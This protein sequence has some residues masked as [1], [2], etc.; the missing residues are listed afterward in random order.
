MDRPDDG[1]DR[2]QH[3]VPAAEEA[4]VKGVAFFLFVLTAVLGN[5]ALAV[6]DPHEMLPA[7][8]LERR[9]EAIGA[10]LRCLVCQNESIEASD[11]DLAR[12][13]RHVIRERVVAGATDRQILQ[14][15]VARYG[16]FVRLRPRFDSV[17]ALLWSAPA[18]ALAAGFTIV[19]L[20]RRRATP[21][22]ATLTGEERLR[23]RTFLE[24]T[25]E[26]DHLV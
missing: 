8:A 6:S 19:A 20:S 1:G 13:L 12:D 7:R 16:D 17:T 24:S 9:A 11:S 26:H 14:W 15:M 4:R 25:A 10:Q 18:L 21:S 3:A 5:H 23:L 2:P 22:D